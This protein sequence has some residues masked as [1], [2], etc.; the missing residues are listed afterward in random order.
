M[1]VQAIDDRKNSADLL[2]DNE[3]LNNLVE[4]SN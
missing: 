2:K 3:E 4:E 1:T